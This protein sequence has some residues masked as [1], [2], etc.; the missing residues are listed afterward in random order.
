VAILARQK[1]MAAVAKKR[2]QEK[3]QHFGSRKGPQ[4]GSCEG[5]S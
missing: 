5:S 3:R 2:V 4:T 1:K